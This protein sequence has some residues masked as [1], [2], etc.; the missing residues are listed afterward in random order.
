MFVRASVYHE[1]GGFDADYFAHMEEI[2]LCWRMKNTGH[3]IYVVPAST[4]FHLGGG[5]L[6]AIS[7]NKTYLNFRNNLVTFTK[8]HPTGAW[9]WI[10][11]LRL[12]LDGVAG[13]KFLFEGRALHTWAVIRAHWAYYFSLGST[14]RKRK[15]MRSRKDFHPST[16]GVYNGN[17]VKDFYLGKMKRFSELPSEKFSA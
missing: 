6:S 15:E 4:V 10:L 1:L 9:V 14:L 5:T 11:L 16:T 8:D 2:D 7:P 13:I 3:K 17:I 12:F